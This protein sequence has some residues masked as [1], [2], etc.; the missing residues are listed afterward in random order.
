MLAKD[1]SEDCHLLPSK[2]HK[3]EGDAQRPT[4]CHFWVEKHKRFCKLI[5]KKGQNYCGEHAL[6]SS[7]TR[8]DTKLARERIPCPYD[9]SHTAAVDRL[10]KHMKYLCNS[11]LA[12]DDSQLPR[13]LVRDF[14]VT[15]YPP[16]YS[17]RFLNLPVDGGVAAGEEL[18]STPTI[19]M[20][21]GQ[22]FSIGDPRLSVAPGEIV[23][24]VK[25]SKLYGSLH[26]VVRELGAL[27]TPVPARIITAAPDEG[28][29]SNRPA[30]D[31]QLP[32]A[33]DPRLHT[34]VITAYLKEHHLS[35]G[36]AGSD[37]IADDNIREEQAFELLDRVNIDSAFPMAIQDHP[38]LASQKQAKH[39]LKHTAQHASF[40]GHLEVNGLLSDKFTYIE[41]GAGKGEL[42]ACL[43][44]AMGPEMA[45]NTDF[46]LVDRKN[47]RS[48]FDNS[49]GSLDGNGGGRVTRLFIDIRDLDLSKLGI[50]VSDASSQP[51]PIVAFSKHLCGSAT[52]LTIRCIEN[53]QK[54]GGRVAG[55]IVAL[56]C[57][58]LC[59][60][61]LYPN[62]AYLYQHLQHL[63]P[64]IP[65]IEGD[66]NGGGSRSSHSWN[67]EMLALVNALASVSS[68]AVC[69]PNPR[70]PQNTTHHHPSGLDYEQR[71]KVGFAA[72]RVLDFGRVAY[73]RQNLDLSS[74]RLVYYVQSEHTLENLLMIAAP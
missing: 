74:A 53:Y 22:G 38:S 61:A 34:A 19:Y 35:L 20:V 37:V 15:V 47:F 33:N 71:R 58:H 66:D 43:R 45:A 60:Y 24:L 10:E 65:P 31:K 54:S 48:K 41:F 13:H 62:Q 30:R 27:D 73:L 8:H 40:L 23:Y 52:D 3:S 44:R 72:K 21:I 57:H 25:R 6:Y 4:G 18:G 17:E 64:P 63:I 12:D 1:A 14:N 32:G 70:S 16:E 46:I 68:W 59:R 67:A 51:K 39:N 9:I 29:D 26:E 50:L 55:F 7:P 2:R 56:C 5:P 36:P 28:D 49:A 11:R 69:G 42:T